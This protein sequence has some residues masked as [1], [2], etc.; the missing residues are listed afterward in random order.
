MNKDLRSALDDIFDECGFTPFELTYTPADSDVITV[1][2]GY[3]FYHNKYSGGGPNF[4]YKRLDN[5]DKD[6]MELRNLVVEIKRSRK[7]KDRIYQFQNIGVPLVMAGLVFQGL[8][9]FI[10]H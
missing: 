8:S 2:Q 6:D 9:L 10:H 3:T 5:F 7:S 4:D 1:E